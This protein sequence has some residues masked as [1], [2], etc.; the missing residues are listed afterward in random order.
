MSLKSLYVNVF[1]QQTQGTFTNL[2]LFVP[3]LLDDSIKIIKDKLFLQE[4]T[5]IPELI[6]LEIY[7]QNNVKIQPIINPNDILYEYYPLLL[8]ENFKPKLH[9]KK[10]NQE[11]I[12]KITEN[13]ID[14]NILNDDLLL[15]DLLDKLKNKGYYELD[16]E[17]LEFALKLKFNEEEDLN[18]EEDE[19]FLDYSNK[20]FNE[21]NDIINKYNAYIDK[22]TGDLVFNNN[23]LREFEN[24]A[25]EFDLGEYELTISD[26]GINIIGNNVKNGIKG[27]FIKLSEIFNRFELNSNIP[28]IALGKRTSKTKTPQIK[29]YNNILDIVS[30]KEVKGWILNEKIKLTQAN[31]KIIK[32][33]LIKSRLEDSH[34]FITINVLENGKISVTASFTQNDIYINMDFKE[35]YNIILDNVNSVIIYLN[36]FAGVFLQG[37]KIRLITDS[38]IQIDSVKTQLQ[39]NFFI[40]RNKL[41]NILNIL[42]IKDNI[43]E[44]KQT[45]GDSLSALY[46]KFHNKE[47]SDIRGLNINIKDYSYAENSSIIDISSSD[48]NQTIIIFA[49]IFILYILASE[50]QVNSRF[51]TKSK[52]RK[53]LTISNKKKLGKEGVFFDSKKCQSL[54]QPKINH[55]NLDPLDDSYILTYKLKNYRCD[56]KVYSYPGFTE[57]NIVC[58]FKSNQKGRDEYVRNIDPESLTLLV[59]PSNFKV[60]INKNNKKFKVFILKIVSE[61]RQGFNENNS[62][63]KYF[64]LEH[65]PNSNSNVARP[66]IV[67]ITNKELLQEIDKLDNIWLDTVSLSKIVYPSTKSECKAKPNL[68]NVGSNFKINDACVDNKNESFFGYNNKSLPCCFEKER[69][70][71]TIVKN[72]KNE[73][74]NQY[75]VKSDTKL[76][77]QNKLGFLPNELINL[78]SILTKKTKEF[79]QDIES[80][81]YRQGTIINANNSFLYV[82]L[83][84]I[85]N[86]I[87]SKNITNHTEFKNILNTYL[88]TNPNEFDKLNNGNLL[89]KYNDINSYIRSLDKFVSWYDTIELLE[90]IIKKNIIILEVIGNDIN[91]LCKPTA[92]NPK[93][94]ERKYI[95]LLKRNKYFEL[96]VKV[97]NPNPNSNSYRIDK[98]NFTINDSIINFLLNYHKNSCLVKNNFPVSEETLENIYGEVINNNFIPYIPLLSFSKMNTLITNIPKLGPVKYQ[99]QNAFSKVNY[100]MTKKGIILPI[101]ETGITSGNIKAVK[102][103]SL[104]KQKDILLD[105]KT[106]LASVQLLKNH[107]NIKIIGMTNS[108]HTNINGLLTNFGTFIPYLISKNDNLLISKY[109][110]PIL[111]YKYFIDID[112]YISNKG[113]DE[114]SNEFTEYSELTDDI[115]D[116]IYEIKKQLGQLFIKNISLKSTISDIILR[117]NIDKGSKISEIYNLIKPFL[118]SKELSSP[119]HFYL[120]NIINDMLND[121][122]E[123]LILNNVIVHDSFNKDDIKIRESESVLLNINDINKW[124]HKYTQNSE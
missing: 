49:N 66:K 55:N 72:K 79:D 41:S 1:I 94:E 104:L 47:F 11:D 63:S 23:K 114:I 6:L 103:S 123:N 81:F 17:S 95:L 67:Q 108:N 118:K 115:N 40:D 121:N 28:F 111:S 99:L 88:K 116:D 102:I 33:L 16:K 105:L 64:Y 38:I 15:N 30:G 78:F 19:D 110:I 106:Y 122:K 117:T 26:I 36:N 85:D 14:M 100:L 43:L 91:I 12:D 90:K 93:K 119:L 53:I 109:K 13:R 92:Y 77:N 56:N 59:Q 5:L 74:I 124:V 25:R 58:C 84:A 48:L 21:R 97:K 32:G 62:V 10:L 120:K 44:K 80:L 8:E 112:E 69:P 98:K 82:I 83:S 54:R 9:V 68:N 65:D 89:L 76:L 24:A 4:L 113:K 2:E 101:F 27:T 57:N 75:I 3:I 52:E 60:T 96:I 71:I 46:K 61:Y 42:D 34:T 7:D 39:T 87:G 22:D 50:S 73:N 18:L 31:Y 45:M 107:I 35:I 20:K 37:E 86:N 29:A 51:F 70:K